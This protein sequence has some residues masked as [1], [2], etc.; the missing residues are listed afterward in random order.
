MSLSQRENAARPRAPYPC[1]HALTT[2]RRQSSYLFVGQCPDR[3]SA[4]FSLQLRACFQFLSQPYRLSASS[5][6]SIWLRAVAWGAGAAISS[7]ALFACQR[8]WN[9]AGSWRCDK[10]SSRAPRAPFVTEEASS[11]AWTFGAQEETIAIVDCGSGGHSSRA[12][13]LPPLRAY[14][15]MPILP[16]FLF[17][18]VRVGKCACYVLSWISEPRTLIAKSCYGLGS[19]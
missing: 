15:A 12:C 7:Y 8:K 13:S 14:T 18:V 17:E 1:C 2:M 19:D 4:D 9:G 3:S 16:T 11:H 6:P 10:T 5:S